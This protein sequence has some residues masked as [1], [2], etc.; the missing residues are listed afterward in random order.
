MSLT[1][2][3]WGRPG[4][5]GLEE[6]TKLDFSGKNAYRASG[7][8]NHALRA[9]ERVLDERPHEVEMLL[10][11]VLTSLSQKGALMVFSC[12]TWVERIADSE[13]Q[14]REFLHLGFPPPQE[15]AKRSPLH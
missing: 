2:I 12:P 7:V 3:V 11:G 15:T 4:P 8:L 14:D 6:W 1:W 10:S 9:I 13:G 5:K